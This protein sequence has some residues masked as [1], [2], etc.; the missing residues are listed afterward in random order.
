[1][2]NTRLLS[3]ELL[4]FLQVNWSISTSTSGRNDICVLT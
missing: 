2:R 3:L 1:M 4:D